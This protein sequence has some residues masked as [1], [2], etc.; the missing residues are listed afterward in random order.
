MKP[1]FKIPTMKE[2]AEVEHNGFYAISTFSG[3]GGSSLG[4]R[5]A[6]FKVLYANEFIEAA[7]ETYKA[8]AGD[9]TIVDGSDIRDVKPE[10]ILDQIKMMPGQLDLLD[11]SPPCS[12]FSQA[13]LRDKG[14]GIE[15]GY[16]DTEQRVDDLFFEYVRLL[17]VIRP[18]VF[19]AENVSGLV[20][21]V[22]KGYFK[23][24]MKALRESGYKVEAKLLDAQWLGVP[25]MRQRLIFQGVR[26][27]LKANPVYPR[28]FPYR[29]GTNEIMPWI[30]A[31]KYGGLDSWVKADKPFSTVMANGWKTSPQGEFNGGSFIEGYERGVDESCMRRILSDYKGRLEVDIARWNES[32]QEANRATAGVQKARMGAPQYGT[33]ENPTERRRTAIEEIK[34]ISTFPIDFRLEGSYGQK[35]ERVGRAV[36]PLMMKAIAST[37]R[38]EV[39]R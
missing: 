12:A 37:I 17:R 2:I 25:Q 23:Q 7:R 35:W 34:R 20:R 6:G 26:E 3:C 18:K 31:E 28:P 30:V 5:M 14:W 21:G 29:Y 4:Y 15:K 33:R 27:D 39:L 13:G 16:S 32:I 36:P 22:S 38:D 8:N 10:D 11:G 24:I 9:Y 19:V 1:E